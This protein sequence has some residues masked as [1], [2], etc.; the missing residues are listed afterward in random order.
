MTRF[1]PLYAILDEESS[2]RAGWSIPSLARACLA[3][4]ARLLQIRAKL[5]AGG[6]LLAM[7]D[8]V[9]AETRRASAILIVNDRA[10]V[11]AAAGADGIHLGQDDLPVSAVV[12][13][14]PSLDLIG[15]S[16]HSPEQVDQA[17][18]G[19]AAY[20]SVGP[21]FETRTKATADRSVGVELVGYAVGRVRQASGGPSAARPVVAIGGITLERAPEVIHAGATSVA[22]ISDLLST[23]DPEGRVRQYVARLGR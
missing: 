2:T 17:A 8:E 14:F 9:L 7:C 6:A 23:G 15:V 3:G 5:A 1:P 4:G 20:I 18:A 22:V 10:D 13:T 12:R 21:V 11:A 19:P 16:T